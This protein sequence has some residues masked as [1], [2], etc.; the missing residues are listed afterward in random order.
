MNRE[1][2]HP[3]EKRLTS[4]TALSRSDK[5]VFHDERFYAAVLADG[6]NIKVHCT[7]VVQR[8]LKVPTNEE[9]GT[10]LS[11]LPN[12][13]HQARLE[14]GS[15]KS[16]P[17]LHLD[18][19]KSLLENVVEY[20]LPQP[21]IITN[22][23]AST[24]K[25]DEPENKLESLSS[26]HRR[27]SVPPTYDTKS[28]SADSSYS[29]TSVQKTAKHKSSRLIIGPAAL[30]S[31][32]L[33]KS[34]GG[35]ASEKSVEMRRAS[36]EWSPRVSVNTPK[37]R[38]SEHEVSWVDSNEID[39]SDKSSDSDS[40]NEVDSRPSI[41]V[42]MDTPNGR[43]RSFALDRLDDEIKQYLEETLEEMDLEAHPSDASK[44]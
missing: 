18:A 2:R 19:E 24:S 41:V 20:E 35:V 17:P 33:D 34:L 42:N 1:Q 12:P 13:N 10:A 28:M 9:G 30:L 6:T 7:T 43:K 4:N 44:E 25:N 26:S 14:N 23:L 21:L 27:P 22:K 3:E 37:R 16:I 5:P 40:G 11:E 32:E 8:N 36:L 31:S 39:D 29:G 38:I 15:T